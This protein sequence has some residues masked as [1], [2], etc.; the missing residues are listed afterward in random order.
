M[1]YASRQVVLTVA[2]LVSA[3][4]LAVVLPVSAL[5]DE[6]VSGDTTTTAPAVNVPQVTPDGQDLIVHPAS[7]SASAVLPAKVTAPTRSFI[8]HLKRQ[9]KY[10]RKQIGGYQKSTDY[11]NHVM[12][13]RTPVH[14]P[15]RQLASLDLPALLMQKRWW[16]R[17]AKQTRVQAQH[18]PHLADFMCIHRYEGSWTDPNGP[19]YGGLQM[20]LGFQGTYG[21]WLLRTKGTADHWTPLEQIWVAEKAL[22]TRGFWPWPNTAH[23]C[24]LI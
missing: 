17:T 2:L 1:R 14:R 10:L 23:Y 16:Q 8:A 21:G 20:N 12:G 11:W 3:V 6:P 18:P 19:Y 4:V 5:A 15:T 9:M 22:R 13:V 24:G 7:S